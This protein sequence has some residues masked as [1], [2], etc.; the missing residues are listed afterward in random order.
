MGPPRRR[1]RRHRR[2]DKAP[3]KRKSATGEKL[4]LVALVLLALLSCTGVAFYLNYIPAVAGSKPATRQSST[5]VKLKI[6]A[7]NAKRVA[8]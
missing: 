5:R 1:H 6:N 7:S 2:P 4:E 3:S 8:A